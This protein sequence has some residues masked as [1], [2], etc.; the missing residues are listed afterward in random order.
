VGIRTPVFALLDGPLT[1]LFQVLSTSSVWPHLT[2][3][4]LGNNAA[5]AVAVVLVMFWNFFVNRY[6]TYNDVD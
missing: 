6:W 1:A 4:F 3:E 5:L 2:A